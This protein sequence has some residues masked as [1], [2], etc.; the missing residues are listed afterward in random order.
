M[1][2]IDGVMFVFGPN[3]KKYLHL[4]VKGEKQYLNAEQN[5]IINIGMSQLLVFPR[6]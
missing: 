3:C 6:P 2:H 4:G 5:T 1:I